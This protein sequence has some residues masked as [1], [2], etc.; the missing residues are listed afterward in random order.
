MD[1]GGEYTDTDALVGFPLGALR[2]LGVMRSGWG[3]RHPVLGEILRSSTALAVEETRWVDSALR[4]RVAADAPLIDL[5]DELVVSVRC[6]VT[7]DRRR[8]V[9][10]TNADG[11]HAWPGGRREPGESDAAT[12]CREVHEE[13]GWLI[14]PDTLRSLGW[15]HFEH[16]ARV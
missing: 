13:T 10:C 14:E 2:R 15:L 6:V 16:L 7:V 3:V 12:A 1:D 11:T 5:P 4:L 8:L 9:L